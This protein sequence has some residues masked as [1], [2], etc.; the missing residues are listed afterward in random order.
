[1]TIVKTRITVPKNNNR[2]RVT[3]AWEHGDADLTTYCTTQFQGM[4]DE[5]LLT[6]VQ[7]FRKMAEAI[8]DDRSCGSE[9]FDRDAW[10][11]SLDIPYDKIYDNSSTPPNAS[12]D[13]IEWVDDEGIVYSVKG[14]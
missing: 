4:S 12:I 10:E 11:L 14:Y 8:D 3:V 6:W 1:M 9:T 13:K 7:N 5:G 2:F